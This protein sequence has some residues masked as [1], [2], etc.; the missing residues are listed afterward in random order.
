MALL[1]TTLLAIY[2]CTW[3]GEYEYNVQIARH[4]VIL[5]WLFFLTMCYTFPK[6]WSAFYIFP[7][8]ST[9]TF[10][11]VGFAYVFAAVFM[12]SDPTLELLYKGNI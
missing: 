2:T 6:M 8:P 1:A 12:F 9:T 4:V 10:F 11:L 3:L 7:K 5:L